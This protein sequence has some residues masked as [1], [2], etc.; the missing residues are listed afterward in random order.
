MKKTKAEKAI[1]YA[2]RLFNIRSRSEKELRERLYEKGFNRLTADD[3]V[4]LL[5]E[6]NILDDARFA[7]L[8]IESRMRRNPKGDMLLRKE[9][10]DKGIA[11]PLIECALSEKKEK[12]DLIIRDIARQ[13]VE[14]LKKLP[15]EKAKKKLFDFLAR[16]GFRFDII[17]D[18]I[19]E[20]FGA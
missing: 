8:W 18:V 5:K 20:N 9:L 15:K 4:S 6:K 7:R 16:R 12:E 14:A 19:K 17:Y 10:W 11:A 3:V 1:A 2:C 13:K